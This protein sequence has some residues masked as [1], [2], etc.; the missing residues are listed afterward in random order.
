MGDFFV[1][2]FFLK[3]R[4]EVRDIELDTTFFWIYGV[5]LSYGRKFLIFVSMFFFLESEREEFGGIGW[6]LVSRR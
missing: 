4:R 3:T 2:F 5:N 1:S 6:Y